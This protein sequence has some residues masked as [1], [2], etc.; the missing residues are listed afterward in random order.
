MNHPAMK[1]LLSLLA[2]TTIPASALSVEASRFPDP[3]GSINSFGLRLFERLGDEGKGTVFSPWSIQ[4]ALAMTL[5]GAAGDTREEMAK[6]LDLPAEPGAEPGI[7]GGFAQ[8][9]RELEAI[10]AR[11]KEQVNDAKRHGGPNT[12]VEIQVANRLFGQ[13][14]Y[15][16][17]APFLELT[18]TTYR[19]PLERLDFEKNPERC[20]THINAWVEQQTRDRIKDLIPKG[21]ITE[22]TGLVLANAV[23]LKAPWAEEFAKQADLPFRVAGTPVKV[24]GL[25]ITKDLGYLKVPGFT[26]AAVPYSDPSLQFV[27]I[28][29]DEGKEMSG[30]DAA[31]LQQAA[32]MP[33]RKVR[34]TMP[35]FRL[36]PESVR[37]KNH[38]TAMGMRKAF[39][40]PRRSADFSR[41]APRRPDEYLF[42]G[43]VVHKAFIAVDE[44]GTEAAAATAVVMI[45]GTMAIEEEQPIELRV[46]RPFAF[47]IQY[48][49]SG[50]CLFLGRVNDPR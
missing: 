24:P 17:E 7:H 36:E 41:M 15:A 14:G 35:S 27:I 44:Y 9:T 40:E 34:L 38:L 5:A 13:E 8:L 19:A 29:P 28:L 43:D 48:R 37:L 11:S 18:E 47:A 12:P 25:A 22:D 10:A 4:S 45:R 50:A 26:L 21:V 3:G 39:D 23:Y 30:L 31:V 6:V 20:R 46:D 32:A 2:A 49:Q 16:F 1:H 33:S 42:I